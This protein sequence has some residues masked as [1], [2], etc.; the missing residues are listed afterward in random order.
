MATLIQRAVQRLWAATVLNISEN[1]AGK[2]RLFKGCTNS[3][4]CKLPRMKSSASLRLWRLLTWAAGVLSLPLLVLIYSPANAQTPDIGVRDTSVRDSSLTDTGAISAAVEQQVRQLAIAGT[5]AATK[6]AALGVSRVDISV[7]ALD[8]RLRLAPCQRI[9][10]YLPP[11][12][13]L[14]GKTRIGLRC[15]QGAT[16]WNVYLPITVKVYG[17]ALVSMQP[18]AAGSVITAADLTKGEVDL[19]EDSSD[20]VMQASQAV[21]RTLAKPMV[22][23]QSLRL[24]HLKLRQW[25]AAGETVQVLAQGSGF[26]IASEGQALTA[27]IEG[28]PARVRTEGGRVLTGVAVAERKMELAL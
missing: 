4:R 13:K 16:A 1:R 26:K 12:A 11:N 15:T 9:E 6:D 20:A 2:A 19:A 10:P 23:G 28:Q 7:G 21:G 14:W 27:G 25:F 5:Q 18:L 8:K 3:P 22:T 24:S 17:Q